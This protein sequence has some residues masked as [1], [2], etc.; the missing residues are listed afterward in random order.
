MREALRFVALVLLF[1]SIDG[2]F[3][4]SI[5]SSAYLG[6]NNRRSAI[7]GSQI[8]RR[9]F[10]AL[11]FGALRENAPLASFFGFN[12]LYVG[13][14]LVKQRVKAEGDPYKTLQNVQLYNV[15]DGQAVRPTDYWRKDQRAVVVF[16]RYLLEK[17]GV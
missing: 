16:L 8:K 7:C 14:L 9:H 15:P 1:V 6:S 3:H 13:Q 5:G 2:F 4:G 10:M 17:F 12:A 11:D